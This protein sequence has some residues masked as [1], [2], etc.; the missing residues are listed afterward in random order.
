MSVS[1]DHCYVPGHKLLP[2]P[3]PARGNNVQVFLSTYLSAHPSW[4]FTRETRDESEGEAGHAA[5][6]E[7]KRDRRPAYLGVELEEAARGIVVTDLIGK[8]PAVRA[9][10]QA[11]TAQDLR[12]QY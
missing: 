1:T 6:T 5:T 4:S 12:S 9:G 2:S 3:W 11:R 10:D 7:T 8:A